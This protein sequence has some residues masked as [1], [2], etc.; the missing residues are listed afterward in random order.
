MRRTVFILIIQLF[1]ILTYGQSADSAY[2]TPLLEKY[3]NRCVDSLETIE[4]LKT[5]IYSKGL[6]FCNLASCLG[7]LEAYDEDTLLNQAI[8]KRL[9]QIAHRF[10]N[11]GTPVLIYSG[12]MNSVETC[13]KLNEEGN[14]YGITYV[15]LGNSCL[16][17]G[18]MDKG[19]QY[20][21]AET[22][23]L[24]NFPASD[25]EKGKKKRKEKRGTTK[26]KRH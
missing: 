8:F 23:S 1:P 5:N 12:G 9:Q 3:V 25:D 19:I 15:S 24:V 26:N 4:Y 13:Q 7:F 6:E 20:F 14:S 2:T 18:S 16:S 11:E 17:F 21:N 10:Y 22:K